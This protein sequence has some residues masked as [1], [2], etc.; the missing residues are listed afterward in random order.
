MVGDMTWFQLEAEAT[1]C[2]GGGCE[3]IEK[4]TLQSI[5]WVDETRNGFRLLLSRERGCMRE[6]CWG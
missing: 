4:R 3:L 2:E 1:V 5:P 6:A